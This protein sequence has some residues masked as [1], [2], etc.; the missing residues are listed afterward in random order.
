ML[1]APAMHTEM[2]EHPATQANVETLRRHGA[3]VM[4]PASGRLTGTDTG[5]GRLPE[6]ASR[7][8]CRNGR[9]PC[10]VTWSAAVW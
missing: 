7:R 10:R 6:P 5:P 8:C 4:E 1:F 3:V 9:T 2:W